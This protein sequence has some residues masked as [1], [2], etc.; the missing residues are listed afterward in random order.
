ALLGV[1][2]LRRHLFSG[3]VYFSEVQDQWSFGKWTA[4]GTLLLIIQTHMG[5]PIIVYYSDARAA[6]IFSAGANLLIILDHFTTAVLTVQLPAVS[7][8]TRRSEYLAY[9]RRSLLLYVTVILAFIPFVFLARP[10]ILFLY[11]PQYEE[12]VFVLQVLFFGYLATLL[13]HPLYL[14]FLSMK[15]PHIYTT[16]AVT[17]FVGWLLAAALLIPSLAAEGAAWSLLFAR[18]VQAAV[19]GYMLWHVLRKVPQL[20]ETETKH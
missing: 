1:W 6:G 4:F 9:I 2:I 20:C 8:L 16:M 15:R 7:R 12:S 3:K 5:I 11:G 17:S 19:I 18:L 14:V 10:A 13:T